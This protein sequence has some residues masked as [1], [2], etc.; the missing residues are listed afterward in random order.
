MTGY[1]VIDVET[2]GLSSR[3]DRVIELA[4]VHTD[5]HGTITGRWETL[6][7]PQR[8]LTAQHI[9]HIHASHIQHAP[10]F[11]DIATDLLTLLDG[12]VPVAHN[13]PFD[14]RFLAAELHR[15]GKTLHQQHDFLCTMNLSRRYLPGVGKTLAD[16]LA[17]T[18]ITNTGAHTALA[19]ATATAQLLAHY[20]HNSPPTDWEPHLTKATTNRHHHAP[21]P[22][23]ARW[24]PRANATPDNT[25]TIILNALDPD[26]FDL[27]TP[28]DHTT[29]LTALTRTITTALTQGHLTDNDT[30]A[31]AELGNTMGMSRDMASEL[32]ERLYRE[33]VQQMPEQA[34]AIAH[35]LA[36]GD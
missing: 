8:N 27:T 18:N 24:H 2:T 9:H 23:T 11:A 31:L 29:Y 3:N 17:A 7:N 12:R 30:Y 19:D 1:A 16:C 28:T 22:L 32:H 26:A 36:V 14:A 6:I 5:T 33:L 4:V 10:L 20:I 34:T 21:P 15:T 13:A 25:A 35:L